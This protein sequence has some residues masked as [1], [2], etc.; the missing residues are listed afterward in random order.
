MFHSELQNT[1]SPRVLK[2]QPE[3]RVQRA[4]GRGERLSR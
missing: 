3:C 2:V 1:L 4:G